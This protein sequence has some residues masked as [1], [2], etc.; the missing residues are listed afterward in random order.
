MKTVT[1]RKTKAGKAYQEIMQAR[2]KTAESLE[3]APRR[4]KRVQPKGEAD[5]QDKV[6]VL[7]QTATRGGYERI[8]VRIVKGD[9]RKGVG[10]VEDQPK[11]AIAPFGKRVVPIHLGD[12]IHFAGG[13]EAVR[14]K[15]VLKSSKR[16]KADD[17]AQEL[18]ASLRQ[19]MMMNQIR[20]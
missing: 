18:A 10:V 20:G 19:A 3:K 8:W 15:V 16:N 4:P 14:P 11:H 6:A 5:Y 7:A 13:N 2:S 17:L 1:E 12:T 9:K